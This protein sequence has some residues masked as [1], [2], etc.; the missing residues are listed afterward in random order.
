MRCRYV[1]IVFMVVFMV[2]VNHFRALGESILG[3][4]ELKS[5]SPW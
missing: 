1:C 3:C 5:T 4:S 2:S